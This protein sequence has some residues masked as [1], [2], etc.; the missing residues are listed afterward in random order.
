[1]RAEVVA[2]LDNPS[3]DTLGLVPVV[4]RVAGRL[5]VRGVAGW[6]KRTPFHEG[7]LED[8]VQ[9]GHALQLPAGL[10]AD[11]NERFPLEEAGAAGWV[12]DGWWQRAE[13]LHL[14]HDLP[15][16]R[17]LRAPGKGSFWLGTPPTVYG[18]L[19]R[20]LRKAAVTALQRDGAAISE[21][22]RRALPHRLETRAITWWTRPSEEEKRRRLEWYVRLERDAGNQEVTVEGLRE[23]F[24]RFVCQ[25]VALPPARPQGPLTEPPEKG[26]AALATGHRLP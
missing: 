25:N 17:P 8:L 20:W 1:M 24:E 15:P 4:L 2:L 21:L 9:Q 3:P 5:E 12:G 19:D 10:V 22:M 16:E 7:D 14:V 11:F 6:E 23:T 26:L 13:E 18:V